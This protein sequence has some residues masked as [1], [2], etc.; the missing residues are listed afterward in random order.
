[1]SSRIHFRRHLQFDFDVTSIVHFRL[2]I[3]VTCESIPLR[4]RLRTNSELRLL[5]QA[6]IDYIGHIT[7]A[8]L[9]TRSFSL[10]NLFVPSSLVSDVHVRAE[11]NAI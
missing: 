4:C 10:S 6:A 7:L 2:D 9:H 8:S 5:R 1:M 3:A 11:R